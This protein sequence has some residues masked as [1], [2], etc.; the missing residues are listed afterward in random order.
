VKITCEPAQIIKGIR[1]CGLSHVGLHGKQALPVASAR[2]RAR[3]VSRLSGKAGYGSSPEQLLFGTPEIYGRCG[4]EKIHGHLR[5][6]RLK[7][8]VLA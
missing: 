7:L 5:G 4:S 6:I 8:T 3:S 2:C 1:S